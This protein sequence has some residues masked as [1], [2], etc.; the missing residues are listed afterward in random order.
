M[1]DENKSRRLRGAFKNALVWGVTWGA[2]GSVVAAGIRLSDKIPLLNALIDGLGMGIRIG[3]VG[4]ISGGAFAAFISL[5]YRNKR[6]SEISWLRFG[7]GG[8]ILGGVFVPSFLEI[9]NL[10]SGGGLVPWHLVSDD[11]IL[12][13][14]FGGITAAGVM[15]LAQRDEEKN[16]VTMGQLFEQMERDTLAVGAATEIRRP[17]RSRSAEH[18]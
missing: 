17:E 12:S 7:I 18:L 13:A 8:A 15:K 3:V 16:P 11:F 10:I 2:L 9:M 1:A 14:A 4:A 5:A 6:L